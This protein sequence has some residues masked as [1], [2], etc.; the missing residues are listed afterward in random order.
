MAQYEMRPADENDGIGGLLQQAEGERLRG[1][2]LLDAV[3]IVA[4]QVRR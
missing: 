4:G 3:R 1:F 2:G